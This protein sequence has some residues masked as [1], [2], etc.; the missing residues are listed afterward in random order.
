MVRP[1]TSVLALGFAVVQGLNVVQSSA[2]TLSELAATTGKTVNLGMLYDDQVLF[3]A[4]VPRTDSLFTV[5][6]RGGS[7]APSVFSSIRKVILA[8]MSD[9]EQTRSISESSFAKRWVPN[10]LRTARGLQI[11]FKA[12]R[13]DG[14]LVQHK[15]AIP[16]LSSIAAPI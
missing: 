6:I 3:A 4:R 11:Q 12:A 14:C 5:E 13:N 7:T 15:K 9:D 2:P 16:G 1:G 10:A 8:S